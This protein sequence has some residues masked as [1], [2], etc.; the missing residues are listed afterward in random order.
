MTVRL[1]KPVLEREI[2]LARSSLFDATVQWRARTGRLGLL[3]D[4]L[5]I[6]AQ[7]GGTTF[8]YD[9]LT[10]DPQIIAA[11][12][13]EVRF[14]DL[15]FQK[16]IAWYRAH[17]RPP[18]GANAA[19]VRPTAITGEASPYYLFHPLAPQ[20]VAALIPNVKLIVLLRNP[21]RRA[22]SHYQHEVRMG[23]EFLSFENA[24]AYE[25]E[26]LRNEED[27]ILRD[28]AYHSL[29]H[30]H[31]SYLSRGIYIDQL[32]RWRRFFPREQFLI[33]PSEALYQNPSAVLRQVLSFL[34]LAADTSATPGH[35]YSFPYPKMN[36][37][38]RQRLADYYRPYNQRL[39]EYLGVDFGWDE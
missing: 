17:F 24:I 19:S 16:G 15:K 3:P 1:S 12:R 8:L 7:K 31:H 2:R 10:Q 6:G 39:Y 30:H 38:T 22:Y 14:F 28:S 13:K 23:F 36:E 20:R 27:K 5:I 26:R 9:L 29:S 4:F 11:L 33:L 18:A 34:G 37:T 25:A 21:I 35:T 32:Q